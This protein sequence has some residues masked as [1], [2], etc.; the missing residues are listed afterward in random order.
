MGNI[1]AT[2]KTVERNTGTSEKTGKPYTRWVFEMDDGKKY[3]TFDEKIG[4]KFKT[5]D[6]VV[7]T[8][9]QEGK[10][11]NMDSMELAKDISP[12]PEKVKTSNDNET[13]D[14]LRQILAELKVMNGNK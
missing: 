5:G 7:M 11:W 1:T 13:N 3:S 12:V 6:V 9:Q 8:G 2:I 4:E 10:Y 14:L